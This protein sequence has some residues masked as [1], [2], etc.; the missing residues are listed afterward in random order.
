MHT[1]SVRYQDSPRAS[2]NFDQEGLGLGDPDLDEVVVVTDGKR[3]GGSGNLANSEGRNED[4]D[5][6]DRGEHC[7]EYVGLGV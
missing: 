6:L 7:E 5:K 1:Q 2:L 3:R 4:E